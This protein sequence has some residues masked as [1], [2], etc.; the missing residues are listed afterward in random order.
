M[1][2]G[3]VVV[4]LAA[5]TAPFLVNLT[6]PFAASHVSE[7]L[8]HARGTL[9]RLT[10]N[11]LQAR[12]GLLTSYDELAASQSDLRAQIDELERSIVSLPAQHAAALRASFALFAG[13]VRAKDEAIA[14][15]PAENALLDNSVRLLRATFERATSH[16]LL[17]GDPAF[18][19]LQALPGIYTATLQCYTE[20]GDGAVQ[21]LTRRL[22]EFESIIDPSSPGTVR[23][24][25]GHA[26]TMAEQKRLVD[27]LLRSLLDETL[28][29]QLD[30]T[31]GALVV[32][33][34]ALDDLLALRRIWVYGAALGTALLV[35]VGVCIGVLRQN[36]D[37]Q[38]Q[39]M[40]RGKSDAQSRRLE[41][42]LRQA[43]K[44]EAVGQLAQGIAHE[45]NTPTQY[46]SD[47]TRFVAGGFESIRRFIDV[48]RE[49]ADP[50]GG[51]AVEA[52]GTTKAIDEAAAVCEIDMLLS[53][54]PSALRDSLSGL[55]CIARIVRSMKS[56]AH[57]GGGSFESMDLNAAIQDSITV[58]THEWKYVADVVT[59][60]DPEL[61]SVQCLQ[62]EIHQVFLNIIV[63][64]AHAIAEAIPHG[65]ASRGIITV[66]TR[67]E[68]GRA[69]VRIEDTGT[70][71]PE[72]IRHRVFEPFF[73]TKSVGKGTGQGLAIAYSVVVEKH[74][75]TIELESEVGK[76]TA[77]VIG[78]PL[79]HSGEGRRTDAL[80]A[81]LAA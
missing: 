15:F 40:E 47:N 30:A 71:I 26:R 4:F 34:R 55:E 12:L 48:C 8:L 57:P 51:T 24:M 2:C 60:L 77:F 28:F 9:E 7:Q 10:G 46:V 13:G 39:V 69:V 58:A 37:L 74:Q 29:T 21:D 67:R 75:G 50:A 52:R 70:G 65:S 41:V 20:M 6:S 78:L 35:C 22:D 16:Q 72:A 59:D 53:E 32:E 79:V 14:S 25:V 76:G 63:N 45:I 38:V 54:I 23:A 80:V 61:G 68:N 3:G 1:L 19:T 64:A 43:Q 56:L 36:N 42:E 66:R 49:P 18:S 17:P 33:S 11:A 81:R 73:T 5:S 31:F 62:G 27:R 44:L